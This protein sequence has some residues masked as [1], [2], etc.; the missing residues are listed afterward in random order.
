MKRTIAADNVLDLTHALSPTFPIW[1]GPANF[2]IRV[3]NMTTVAKDSYYANKW[4]LVEHHG[5][6]LD[7]PAHFAPNG[8]TAEVLD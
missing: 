1:P 2:P 6:H 3:T 8:V 4:E 5:T 7:A